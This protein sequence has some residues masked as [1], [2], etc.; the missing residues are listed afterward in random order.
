MSVV[1]PAAN[2][3]VISKPRFELLKMNVPLVIGVPLEDDYPSSNLEVDD[4]WFQNFGP[5]FC[6]FPTD[7]S[8][9]KTNTSQDESMIAMNH[10]LGSD[11]GLQKIFTSRSFLK[12]SIG[13]TQAWILHT[14]GNCQHCGGKIYAPGHIGKL[15]RSI[16]V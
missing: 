11:L 1:R 3:S 10:A 6:A 8:E 15:S 16:W 5:I 9:H 13:L 12:G 2:S 14:V 4:S 7:I